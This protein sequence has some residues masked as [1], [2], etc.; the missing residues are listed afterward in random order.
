MNY[1]A[2]IMNRD[3]VYR[4]ARRLEKECAKCVF[5]KLRIGKS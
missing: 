4:F 1:V 2:K 5:E 3:F